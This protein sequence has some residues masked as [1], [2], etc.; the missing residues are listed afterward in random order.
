M[1]KNAQY[2]IEFVFVFPLMIL[3]LFAILEYGVY[4][5]NVNLVQDIANEAA[6]VAAT[7][8]ITDTQTST[9][10]GN[11]DPVTGCNAGVLEAMNSLSGRTRQLGI[12]STNWGDSGNYSSGGW[13][14]PP[15]S[16][17]EL[18]SSDTTS[19]DGIA[20]PTVTIFIDYRDPKAEG[21][22]VQISFIHQT[23]LFGLSIPVFGSKEPITIIP[24][25]VSIR[26]TE[27]KQYPGY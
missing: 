7:A 15:Y 9:N 8:H 19:V 24:R 3:S 22:T 1:K 13:G 2:L 12:A 17:F 5:R 25:T 20:T 23:L 16:I 27:V 10:I 4:Y 14:F 21:V 6:V 26:S 18:Q 11:T